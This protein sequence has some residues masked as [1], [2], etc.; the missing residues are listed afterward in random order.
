MHE[1]LN[2]AFGLDGRVAAVTGGASGIGREAARVFAL[3]GARVALID[4][5]AEGLQASAAFIQAAGGTATTHQ[6]DMTRRAEVEAVA[7]AIAADAGR[8]D[9]WINAAGVLRRAPILEI[10]EET[11]DLVVSVNLK[12]VYWGVAAAGR[13]MRAQ[14]RGA[15]INVS[16]AGAD[17]P[18][19]DISVYAMTKAAVN[20]LTRDAAYEFGP[21]GIRV[22]AV[23]PGWVDTPMVAYRYRSD[24]G[25][26]DLTRKTEILGALAKGSPL[27]VTGEPNDIALAMLYLASDASRFVTGQIVR[28]NG[29]SAM[30]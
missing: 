18:L 17:A 29:G 30:P 22:N 4:N 19:P 2:R 16:S 27:G 6:V 25:S 28:P 5:N 10:T 3:A 26:I 12:G 23:G 8:L 21:Y 9:I 14:G 24:D 15:I 7:D 11:L 20:M 13:V 1:E